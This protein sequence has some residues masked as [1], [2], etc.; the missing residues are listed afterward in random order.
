MAKLPLSGLR[1]LVPR[2]GDIG[3]R[4][5]A[6]VT[7]RGGVPVIAPAIQFG[8]PADPR[9]IADACDQLTAG[10]FDWVAVT[11]ATTVETLVDHDVRIPENTRVAV[12]GPATR[13]AM[14]AA[15]FPADFM[16][17]TSFSAAAM[18]EEWPPGRGTVLMPQ[19][20]LA[21]PTL[22]DGLTARGLDVT[23][24]TAYDTTTLDWDD[25]IR[26][27]LGSGEFGAVLFTSPSVARAVAG[28]GVPLPEATVVACIGESTAVGAR[29]AGLSVHVV[30]EAST[31]EGLV[32]ALSDFLLSTQPTRTEATP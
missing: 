23:T 8:A 14:A 18:V 32:A 2:G 13:D 31:A 3:T 25:D 12:V 28:Q 22:A 16:P 5:A 26:H 1:V 4:L 27:R 15:G 30:A 24:V 6:A 10:A 20:A 17:T 11:S 21:E 29:A 9:A 7:A 19:S